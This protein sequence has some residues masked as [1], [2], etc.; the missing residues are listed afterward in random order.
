MAL[1]DE[2]LTAVS[3][4]ESNDSRIV[5]TLLARVHTDILERL[6]AIARDENRIKTIALNGLTGTHHSDHEWLAKHK[7]ALETV[8]TRRTSGGYC[9]IA[10]R[11]MEDEQ[12]GRARRKRIGDAMVERALWVVLVLAVAAIAPDL[13][14][15]LK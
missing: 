5:L 4:V 8:A 13:F 15:W 14:G 1:A 12:D 6:D 2:I 11:I 10:Q 3:Q 9:D 7:S